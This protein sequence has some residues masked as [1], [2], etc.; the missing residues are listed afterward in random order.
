MPF[1]NKVC[2]DVLPCI[3][4]D[5]LITLLTVNH[6]RLRVSAKGINCNRLYSEKTCWKDIGPLLSFLH[7]CYQ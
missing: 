1:F 6:C 3:D 7:W 5:V 2:I 4:V